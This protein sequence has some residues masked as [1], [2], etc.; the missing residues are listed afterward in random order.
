MP[1]RSGIFCSPSCWGWRCGWSH[2][3]VLSRPSSRVA[4]PALL[5]SMEGVT[6]V[7]HWDLGQEG[8]VHRQQEEPYASLEPG[9]DALTALPGRQGPGD[10][11]EVQQEAAGAASGAGPV[12][13]GSAGQMAASLP[14]PNN[15][16]Q[17]RMSSACLEAG[18]GPEE[19]LG[20]AAPP[21]SVG[22]G[23]AGPS[24]GPVSPRIVPPPGHRHIIL[25]VSWAPDPAVHEPPLLLRKGIEGCTQDSHGEG[26]FGEGLGVSRPCQPWGFS[27]DSHRLH[28][29]SAQGSSGSRQAGTHRQALPSRCPSRVLAHS[30]HPVCPPWLKH[31]SGH[32]HGLQL[33]AVSHEARK[34]VSGP[35]NQPLRSVVA[36]VRWDLT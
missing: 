30:L 9:L 11:G 15:S 16:G 8:T 34:R 13:Q 24:Q 10:E 32:A 2:W 36:V 4:P 19:C 21:G 3:E 22:S 18:Q 1:C 29:A 12:K 5:Q 25:G 33:G 28:W 6:G 27:G 20:G 23:P 7:V 26:R 35:Q 17:P 31:L 14:V